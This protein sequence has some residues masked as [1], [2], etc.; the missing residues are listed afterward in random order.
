MQNLCCEHLL[1]SFLF[2]EAEENKLSTGLRK[3]RR[4]NGSFNFM[5]REKDSF[6]NN[7]IQVLVSLGLGLSLVFP[8]IM[9]VLSSSTPI[10]GRWWQLSG[11][12]SLRSSIPKK[13][14]LTFS[15]LNPMKASRF[16]MCPDYR[17]NPLAVTEAKRRG[18]QTACHLSYELIPRTGSVSFNHMYLVWGRKDLQTKQSTLLW[19]VCDIVETLIVG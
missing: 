4:F 14:E 5:V 16:M 1:D 3:R 19:G 6:R 13:Q 18:V 10:V 8:S 15:L 9:E 2:W 17:R 11:F 7:F 12:T